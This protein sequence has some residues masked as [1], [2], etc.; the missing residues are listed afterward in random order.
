MNRYFSL[1][2]TL[3]IFYLINQPD[4]V[5]TSSGGNYGSSGASKL[6]LGNLKKKKINKFKNNIQKFN[7]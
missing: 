1:F 4:F 6:N 7:V 2:V 3:S 5:F